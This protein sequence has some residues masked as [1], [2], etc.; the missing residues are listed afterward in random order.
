MLQAPA[1]GLVLEITADAYHADLVADRPTL[2]SSIAS[3]LCTSSPAHARAAHP[4]LNPGFERV[5]EDKFSV[6]TVAHALL[7][8]GEEIAQI[9][10]AAD[11]RTNVAKQQRSEAQ[12]AGRIPL[13]RK[14][15]DE[16]RR[17]SEAIHAQL[18][19]LELTP[20]LLVDGRPELTLV[21]EDEGV[22]CRA[23]VDWLHDD[24]QAVDD[25]KTTKASANPESWVRTMFTIGA[26]IQAAFYLRGLEVMFGAVDVDWRFLVCETYP[27]YAISVVSPGAD[28]LVLARKK[29]RYALELWRRCLDSDQWPGYPTRPAFAEL[30]PWAENQWLEREL[31]DQAA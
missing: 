17:M 24:H 23:R 3:I 5:E 25:L 29:V 21:W 6:G 18:P 16:V 12:L 31:R 26:D 9:V 15:W 7:L 4:K 13:L 22:L 11:W 30:P 28:V 27:P 20:R 8:Q 14:H 2:S 10:D 1:G 19:G